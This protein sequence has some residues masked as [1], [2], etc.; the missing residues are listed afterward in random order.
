MRLAGLLRGKPGAPGRAGVDTRL[1]VTAALWVLR[2]AAPW[3]ALPPRSGQWKS[4]PGRFTR[5]AKAGVWEK[6]CYALTTER[7]HA[8]LLR[9]SPAGARLS[10]WPPATGGP[11][12]GA[13]ACPRR[14]DGQEPHGWGP[15]QSPAP[16]KPLSG[17]RLARILHEQVDGGKASVV[18]ALG[19]GMQAPAKGEPG[20]GTAGQRGCHPAACAPGKAQEGLGGKSS[21]ASP[22]VLSA[23]LTE[24]ARKS[25]C[26]ALLFMQYAS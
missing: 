3:P 14:A 13:G 7:A 15:A 2:A 24:V 18:G 8:Y 4:A 6:V 16:C 12:A 22:P 17:W 20:P 5:G 1:F 26:L 11:G 10:R 25:G 19:R 21:G 23:E 9:A